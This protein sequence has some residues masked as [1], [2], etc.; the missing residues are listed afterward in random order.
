MNE[1]LNLGIRNRALAPPPLA[2][3]GREGVGRWCCKHISY[4]NRTSYPTPTQP[5]PASGEGVRLARNFYLIVALIICICVQRQGDANAHSEFLLNHQTM[6]LR[7]LEEVSQN[8]SRPERGVMVDGWSVGL[9]PSKAKRSR[10]VNPFYASTR[11]FGDNF[12]A[13]RDLYT[14]LGLPCIFRMTPYGHDAIA[15]DTQLDALG[16]VRFDTTLTMAMS[17]ENV[18]TE[19]LKAPGLH[20]ESEPN[21]QVAAQF[22]AQL[23]GDT[24][25]ERDALSLRWQMSPLQIASRFAYV[26]SA[27]IA[28]AIT[29]LDDGYAGIFDVVTKASERG[30]GYG[31]ALFDRVLAH[32]KLEGAHT[33]YLQVSPDNPARHLYERA[34]FTVAYEYWYRAM[35]HDIEK[36]F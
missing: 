23:R 7:R 30:H 5:S 6:N 9:S 28:H 13:V 1:D 16:F 26:Q 29:I 19:T 35:P 31:T 20:V 14:Q 10:C 17:L 4:S 25:E 21:F 8:A 3:G 24:A 11:S 36:K 34:G 33:A 27:R 2:G 18:K 22:L 32:A 12:D 15:I